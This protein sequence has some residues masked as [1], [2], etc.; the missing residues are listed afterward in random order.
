MDWYQREGPLQGF[1]HFVVLPVAPSWPC[2]DHTGQ[3]KRPLSIQIVHRRICNNLL[4]SLFI[5]LTPP[6]VP[7]ISKKKVTTNRAAFSVPRPIRHLT[8]HP[9]VDCGMVDFL[10]Q[11]GQSNLARPSQLGQGIKSPHQSNFAQNMHPIKRFCRS[12][13][14]P[15]QNRTLIP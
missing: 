15:N 1:N 3:S 10:D 4:S 13:A 14:R 12:I 2:C 11:D 8:R 5:Y 7:F 6:P 9:T